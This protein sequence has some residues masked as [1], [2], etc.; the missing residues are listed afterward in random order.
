ME[1]ILN[2]WQDL[3]DA[4]AYIVLGASVLVKLTPAKWDDTAVAYLM[5]YIALNKDKVTK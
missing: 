2:N 3:L 4:V 5:K 1:F